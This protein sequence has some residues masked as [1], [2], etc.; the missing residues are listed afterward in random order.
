MRELILINSS[1][2]QGNNTFSYRFPHPINMKKGCKLS[3]FSYS[4]YNSTFNISKALGNNTYTV[5]WLNLPAQTFT[6]PDGY[7]SLSDI[8]NNIQFN[9][10]SNLLYFK[11]SAGP[12]YPISVQQNSVQYSS[13]INIAYIPTASQATSLGY[14]VP[15]GASWSFP[16]SAQTPQLTICAGLQSI[17]G[18]QGGQ[19]VFPQTVQSS[20]Q[21][22]LSTNLPILSPTYTYI[23]TCN[24][25]NSNF[26][27]VPTLFQQIPINVS[28][29][30]LLN[31]INPQ[32]QQIDIREG[33]YSSLDLQF[34]NQNM[35]PLQFKDYEMT[36]TLNIDIP[37]Q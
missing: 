36:I 19:S 35:A 20:T 10:L 8:N 34:W 28:Y 16:S 6:M 17:L 37:D 24:M 31:F 25:I 22:F 30:S 14:S 15:S 7:Y 12:V 33:F 1:H 5:T 11:T 18:F 23:M 26:S 2:Y 29:G 27:N 13:Q 4:G 21:Q 32:P 3:L 9:L